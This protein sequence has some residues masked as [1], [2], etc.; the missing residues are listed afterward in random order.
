M[1]AALLGGSDCAADR[2]KC[3]EMLSFDLAFSLL[4]IYPNE[5]TRDTDKDL[6]ARMII[7]ALFIIIK[8]SVSNHINIK[9]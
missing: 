4:G 2:A 7:A 3:L 1:Q 5:I 6:G 9:Q 8:K